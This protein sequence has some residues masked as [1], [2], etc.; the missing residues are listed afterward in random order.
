MGLFNQFCLMCEEKIDFLG[1]DTVCKK[2]LPFSE[3]FL[4]IKEKLRV[5]ELNNNS[6][7]D[8]MKLIL[9]QI[10]NS[11]PISETNKR[12]W[13]EL[14][15]DKHTVGFNYF[16]ELES[17]EQNHWIDY[18]VIH[19]VFRLFG[20]HDNYMLNEE[21]YLN[22]IRESLQKYCDF[23]QWNKI[24]F[25]SDEKISARIDLHKEVKCK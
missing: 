11:E 24:K 14:C 16:K 10:I 19:S 3:R 7:K 2:C 6:L 13:L 20:M 23:H 4:E 18:N 9:S 25:C 17:F 8:F 21:G 5:S 22:Y 12:A 1:D 15:G